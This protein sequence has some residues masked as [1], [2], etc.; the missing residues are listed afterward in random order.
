[1]SKV[2][3]GAWTVVVYWVALIAVVFAF[4]GSAQK[5]ANAGETVLTYVVTSISIGVGLIDKAPEAWDAGQTA[6]DKK[7]AKS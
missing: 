2:K 7:I 5:A 1:M 4:T 6:G 3:D